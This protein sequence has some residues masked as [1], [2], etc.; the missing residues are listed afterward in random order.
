[1]SASYPRYVD[2]HTTPSRLFFEAHM[3]ETLNRSLKLQLRLPNAMQ[4]RRQE[5]LNSIRHFRAVARQCCSALTLA[6]AAG[7]AIDYS[8]AN[9][10][11]KIT[12]DN[13]ASRAVL[14]AVF[15]HDGKALGYQMRSWVLQEL[16][17]SWL[18][19]VWDSLRRDLATA[20]TA[21]DPEFTRASRSWLILHGAREVAKFNRRGIGFPVSTG[22]PRLGGH[23]L[24]LKWDHRIGAIPFRIN[25]LDG[26]AYYHWKSIRDKS[27][28]HDLGTVFLNERDGRLFATV[29]YSM[30]LAANDTDP[31]RTLVVRV[32]DAGESLIS[33][34]GP[35]G[36]HTCDLISGEYAH[37]QLALRY[38]QRVRLEAGR[39][40]CGSPRRP[41]GH[42][43]GWHER[44]A[45]LS[46]ATLGR[47]RMVT[48]CN[49]AWSRRIADRARSWRCGV[50]EL[51]L[52]TASELYRHP[53][54]WSQFEMFLRYKCG[55][56]GAVVVCQNATVEG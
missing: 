35:D 7:A 34:S 12:P 29:S 27:N 52:P 30:P 8:P 51:H 9:D 48:N 19:F 23:T 37:Q 33:L 25:S 5:I 28:G 26:G 46:S 16:A 39:A 44:Q 42:R 41:W 40:A 22:R 17:P 14:A 1:M 15:G 56:V 10:V 20:W 4:D 24:M 6:Q 54:N 49:H 31:T 50:V 47:E 45:A 53:W 32:N 21:K 38:A 2:P 55:E 36:V 11:L 3:S 13:D 18:S 43:R